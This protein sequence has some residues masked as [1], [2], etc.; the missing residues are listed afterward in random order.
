MGLNAEKQLDLYIN[1]L[2]RKQVIHRTLIQLWHTYF[3]NIFLSV[4]P[5]AN[6]ILRTFIRH[7]VP[8]QSY[9]EG[10]PRRSLFAYDKRAG[11]WPQRDFRLPAPRGL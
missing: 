5:Q 10:S 8:E 9:K 6:T 7:N 1:F 11:A 4:E 2:F 3:V